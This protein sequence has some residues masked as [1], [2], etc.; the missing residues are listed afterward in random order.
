[1]YCKKL[2]IKI[3]FAFT[4][5]FIFPH[6]FKEVDA[7][8]KASSAYQVNA[9]V[10]P[11][12]EVQ[13]E[14]FITLT[15]ESNGFYVR[16]Y[17]LLCEYTDMMDIKVL[18]NG[19]VG[20]FRK[21]HIEDKV[22]IKILLQNQLVRNG[23]SVDLYVTYRTR[24]VYKKDG[25]IWTLFIPPIKSEEDLLSV[26]FKLSIPDKLGGISFSSIKDTE[27]IQEGEN[28]VIRYGQEDVPFGALIFFGERQQF[29]FVYNYKLENNEDQKR[30]YS[31][32]LPSDSS[33]QSVSFIDT[34]YLPDRSLSDESG[35]NLIEYI[36]SPGE[37]R[38][39][40]ITGY[41]TYF[42]HPSE[43]RSNIKISDNYLKETEV[44]NFSDD[45]VRALINNITR[46]DFFPLENARLIYDYLIL[47]FEYSNGEVEGSKNVASLVKERPQLSCINLSDLFIG[48]LRGSNIPARRVKGYTTRL[49]D[50]NAL[51]TWVEFY[52]ERQS[53]WIAADPCLEKQVGFSEFEK[54]DLNRII[55][56]YWDGLGDEPTV[57]I[58]FAKFQDISSDNFE[59]N[60]SSY[61]YPK[62][63]Q[64]I[65]FSFDV[66]SAD[67]FFRNIPLTLHVTNNSSSIFRFDQVMIDDQE[68]EFM[69]KHKDGNFLE[70]VFP[71]QTG[72]IDI[73]LIQLKSF[74]AEKI[75]N[76]KLDVFA[77]FG[78]EIFSKSFEFEINRPFT[79][80]HATSW[81]VAGLLAILSLACFLFLVKKL[82][83]K[84][85]KKIKRLKY[86]YR[87]K[88]SKMRG[89]LDVPVSLR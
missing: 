86:K 63:D 69:P 56:N 58:P 13:L 85:W 81:F 30:R 17:S 83:T 57:M 38:D 44:W 71:S 53:R 55:L 48:L 22:K 82:R 11:S 64:N 18:E 72:S 37:V 14:Y 35:N 74:S 75:E 73:N 50:L 84:P 89:L 41:T 28:K 6:Y 80:Y 21:E 20:D 62:E 40:R 66:G 2:L 26:Q 60:T 34:S 87:L 67:L 68:V 88:R 59:V 42:L 70:T 10:L 65:D 27:F 36:L 19:G 77:N 47:N 46:K 8:L 79:W 45:D 5:L 54:L 78:E 4:F 33:Y 61:E 76:Y 3:V 43:S 24:Q 52:D 51:H 25:L 31:I 15:N 32:L 7:F 23:D 12:G 16:D 39:I 29:D 49:E 9:F 1:M